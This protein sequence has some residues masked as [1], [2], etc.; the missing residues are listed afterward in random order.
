[1]VEGLRQAGVGRSRARLPELRTG[2]PFTRF[3][4]IGVLEAPV[5]RAVE[6][7]GVS[8][9]LMGASHWGG[10]SGGWGDSVEWRMQQVDAPSVA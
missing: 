7:N 9:A 10:G 8:Y 4:W 3:E 6:P 1:M 5:G 2:R